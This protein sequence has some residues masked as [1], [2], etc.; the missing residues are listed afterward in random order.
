MNTGAPQ[1]TLWASEH[2]LFVAYL[3]GPD[4]E[5]TAVLRFNS[6]C[7]KFGYPNEEVL[8]GHPLYEY[9]L[10]FYDFH[11]VENSPW[12]AEM[13][14]HNRAHPHHADWLF[15]DLKH[16]VITFHDTTLEVVGKEASVVGIYEFD[17]PAATL[18]QAQS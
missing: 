7:H 10:Q 8:N 18:R 13:R 9:G 17:D 2:E 4:A 1:P 15:A 6:W 11:V 5:K 12:I 3:V 14:G 16:W